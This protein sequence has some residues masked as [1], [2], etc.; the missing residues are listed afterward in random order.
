MS[1]IYVGMSGGV[2]SSAVA[3][4]LQQQGH[5][6]TGITFVGLVEQGSKKCCSLEEINSARKVCDYLGIGHKTLDLKDIFEAKI[7]SRFVRD[8]E[9][10]LTPNPCV[11]CNRHI[12]FG[13]LLEFALSQGADAFATGHYAR[14]AE[15]EGELLLRKA[16]FAPKDQ[17][18]FLSFVEKD[19]LPYMRFP[20]GDYK[21]P[22][23]RQIVD[24]SGMP[25]KADKAESQDV[26]FIK[27]D[28]RDF[29]R[30]AGI[31][32][33]EGEFWYNGAKVGKHKG[34]PFYSYGQRRGLNVALGER[35]FVREF[36]QAQNRIIL[37][38]KP[39]AR[40]FTVRDMNIFTDKFVSGAYD[41]QIRYQ[42]AIIP[43]RVD[44]TE[45]GASIEMEHPQEIVSPG[46]IAVFYVGDLIYAS[47]VIECVVNE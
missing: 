8:Y 1:H 18:Y 29:L 21:K 27:D 42:S 47:G 44:R 25:I 3:W 31:E 35:A 4:L 45:S 5:S 2:D 37:G 12:K 14:I 32:E 23:V 15:V 16:H 34:I 24:D 33:K 11:L 38:P 28:Y 43:A 6:V 19:M 30:G 41:V 39:T 13:A 20:L 46:Q 17:S 26:C 40:R 9:R 22:E 7:V 36:D 10:G